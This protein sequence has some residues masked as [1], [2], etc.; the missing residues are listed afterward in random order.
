MLQ[1]FYK[2]IIVHILSYLT[3]NEKLKFMLVNKS[4]SSYKFIIK[5]DQIYDYEKI[6]GLSFYKNF[7][8]IKYMAHDNK[9]PFGV[10]HLTYGDWF[11]Q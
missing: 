11:N 6:K 7:N 2:D 9:I 3:D 8:K 10:T 4:M 1:S 5:Y